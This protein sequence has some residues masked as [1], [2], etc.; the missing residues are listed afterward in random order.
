MTKQALP[1]PRDILG[2]GGIHVI[3][4]FIVTWNQMETL[5]TLDVSVLFRLSLPDGR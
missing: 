5:M 4:L 2:P 3:G 1:S